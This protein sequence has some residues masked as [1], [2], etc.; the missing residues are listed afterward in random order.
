MK[1]IL[2]LLCIGSLLAAF[3]SCTITKRHSSPGYY[4]E[5]K[6]NWKEGEKATA[7]KQ[8]TISD[9]L[10][11]QTLP[12][13]NTDKYEVRSS[14]KEAKTATVESS[15]IPESEGETTTQ[16]IH[17]PENRNEVHFRDGITTA[18][19]II[20]EEVKNEAPGEVNKP[21]AK[22]KVEPLTWVAFVFLM[23]AVGVGLLPV[24][25]F[26]SLTLPMILFAFLFLIAFINAVSSAMRIKRNPD[27]YKAKWFT[28]LV[29]FFCSLG[30]AFALIFLIANA[31]F[32][33][34]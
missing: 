18:D 1:I 13:V 16:I 28:W 19:E 26:S 4:V 8:E 25:L 20:R 24:T 9:T 2:Q 27:K 3:S 10:Y 11:A 14:K 30:F 7:K 31:L 15:V 29:V 34:Y 17:E 5:W 6:K 21:Q 12:V 32:P 33:A 22:K 23:L